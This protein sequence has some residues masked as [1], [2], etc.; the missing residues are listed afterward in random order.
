MP[1]FGS[2]LGPY[3]WG[4][5]GS[6]CPQSPNPEPAD[7]VRFWRQTDHAMLD[8]SF[9]GFD[10]TRTSSFEAIRGYAVALPE[11]RQT[12][13]VTHQRYWDAAR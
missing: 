2:T 5:P 10:P 1:A 8:P 6:S 9:S 11:A 4:S 3:R 7:W 12:K 13:T